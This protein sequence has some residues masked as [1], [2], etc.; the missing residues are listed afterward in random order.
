M[1]RRP[2][3]ADPISKKVAVQKRIMTLIKQNYYFQM[4]KFVAIMVL[5]QIAILK[6][7]G[8]IDLKVC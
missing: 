7:Q 3:P 5:R 4:V 8:L 6:P 2:P 1:G